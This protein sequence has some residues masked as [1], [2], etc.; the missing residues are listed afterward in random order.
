MPRKVFYIISDVEKAMGFEWIALGIDRRQVALY[1]ILMGKDNT[2]LVSFLKKATIP[3][4]VVPFY[5]KKDVPSA[6]IRVFSILLKERPEVV[7]THL[8]FANLIGLTTAWCLRVKRRIHTR[9]HASLHHQYFPRSVF[10]DKVINFISTDIIALS[11]N[12]QKIL[13]DWEGVGKSKVHLIPH[14]FHL[15]YFSER[16]GR[17]VDDVRKTHNVPATYPVVGLIARFTKWKGIQYV[18][19]AFK[20][21]LKE[22]PQAHL[23]LANATG[24]YTREIRELL[25]RLPHGTYTTIPFEEDSASLYHLFDIYIHTPIDA[26]CE[27]FGQT[28][29]EALA[30]GV[31][32]IF[33]LSGI[34]CDFIEHRKNAWLVKYEDS[35]EIAHALR[36]ILGNVT[37]RNELVY[38]GKISVQ[39]RFSIADMLDKLN[40][41]YCI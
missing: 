13:I 15:S 1:F 14:G 2:P 31:P 12:L 11:E 29:V 10:F 21:L 41:L 8:F 22:Y 17:R 24:D 16:N 33:T 6:W 23:I 37:L 26:Y 38:N 18:I 19:P 32:S 25:S 7:H 5:G 20:E 35:T 40:N 3:H 27:A 36:V 39:E 28:Y 30:A 34:A 4:F 9:H